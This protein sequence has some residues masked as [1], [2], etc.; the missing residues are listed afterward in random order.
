MACIV[1]L[2]AEPGDD[3]V[4]PRGRHHKVACNALPR[5]S[6]V[7]LVVFE[8]QARVDLLHEIE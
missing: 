5:E 3:V 8:V 7:V 1:L 2:E 6:D 4:T